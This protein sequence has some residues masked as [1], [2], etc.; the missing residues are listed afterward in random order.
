[1]IGKNKVYLKQKVN[2]C[3]LLDMAIAVYKNWRSN[4]LRVTLCPLSINCVC[5]RISSFV[6]ELGKCHEVITF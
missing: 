3:R 4:G 5:C 2:I 1:M 6:N